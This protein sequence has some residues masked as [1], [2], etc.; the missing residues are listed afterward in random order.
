MRFVALLQY[1]LR[2][3]L[4]HAC[5]PTQ[6][7]RAFTLV[8]IALVLSGCTQNQVAE[9]DLVL[10][11]RPGISNHATNYDLD[12]AQLGLDELLAIGHQLF[13]ASFNTLDGATNSKVRLFTSDSELAKI[14]SRFNRI[15]GPD[16]NSCVACHNLPGIG[17]G[18]DNAANVFVRAHRLPNVNFDSG[19]GDLLEDLTLTTLG[20]ERG[21]TSMF[22][23]GLIELL[24][25]EMTSDLQ[26]IKRVAIEKASRTNLPAR[27][28]LTTKGV[29]FGTLTV[30]PD[31]LIDASGVQG[32]DEALIIKPF[33][34]KGVYTS[35]REFTLDA[36]EI[37]H[38]LQAEERVGTNKDGDLDGVSDEL[39]ISDVTALTLF[40]A[41][42]PPPSI[43]EP[44]SEVSK[45]YA[46]R[47]EQIFNEIG[48]AVC[49]KPFLELNSPIYSEPNQFNPPG[50]LTNYSILDVY[51]INLFEGANSNTVL[52][53]DYGTYLVYAYT[54]LKRHDMGQLL[55][56]EQIEQ[57][58]V[59]SPVWLTRRLWGMMS[60][61]PFLHHGRATLLDEAIMLHGGEADS[62][63][64]NYQNLAQDDKDSIIEF[65]RTFQTDVK[66]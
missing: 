50:T 57:R 28:F 13:T 54:D 4:S 29:S 19:A 24:A 53:T 10:G 55:A 61:P 2:N 36:L 60:E 40:Q 11:D 48:C 8:L 23:S 41:S 21:T 9:Q 12:N 14:Q 65:L 43:K 42:L 27:V 45:S 6:A 58:F 51:Q 64:A 22:G 59:E 30:W 32:V 7:W 33:S 35:L 31:G 3:S 25:R 17:G 39:T 38:G 63:R 34:Q 18:G 52:R 5:E 15:S 16:A 66:Q 47:G 26:A 49:H 44:E 20:N 62:V 56:N 37:H 1:T 46:L